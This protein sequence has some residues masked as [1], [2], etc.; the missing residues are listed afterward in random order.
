VLFSLNKVAVS[1]MSRL[2]NHAR[3]FADCWRLW[4]LDQTSLLHV[5]V[6]IIAASVLLLIAYSHRYS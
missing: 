4:D 1:D 3:Q 5:L 2:G 6:Y